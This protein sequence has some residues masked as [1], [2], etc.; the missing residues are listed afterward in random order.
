[1]RHAQMMPRPASRGA[2]WRYDEF[3]SDP[4]EDDV[5]P[6]HHFADIEAFPFFI[7]LTY[8]FGVG[9]WKINFMGCAAAGEAPA[10]TS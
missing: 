3:G 9:R 10:R 7:E 4:Q 2:W 8:M 6:E 5:S 1:M